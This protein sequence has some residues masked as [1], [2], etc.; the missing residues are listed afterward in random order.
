MVS[1]RA[2]MVSER[3]FW[4]YGLCFWVVLLFRHFWLGTQKMAIQTLQSRAK[5]LVISTQRTPYNS[6]VISPA[7]PNPLPPQFQKAT[8]DT[9]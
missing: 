2:L 4:L 1:E 7:A 5:I 3:A 6:S 8:K 9:C